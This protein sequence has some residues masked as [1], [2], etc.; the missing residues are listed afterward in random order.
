MVMT[1]DYDRA[2]VNSPM[3]LYHARRQGWSFDIVSVSPEIIE[4]LR[5]THGL[6]YFVTPIRTEVAGNARVVDYLGQFPTI[7]LP[8]SHDGLWLVDLKKK[9]SG[10]E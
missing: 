6:R 10:D 2:G 3:L 7:A 1:V 5:K 4:H 8:D 9:L